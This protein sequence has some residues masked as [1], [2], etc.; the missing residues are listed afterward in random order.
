MLGW[1]LGVIQFITNKLLR[2]KSE[3]WVAPDQMRQQYSIFGLI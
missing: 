3:D 2:L 1:G